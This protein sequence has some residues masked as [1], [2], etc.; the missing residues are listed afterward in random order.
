LTGETKGVAESNQLSIYH[1]PPQVK[2]LT[3]WQVPSEKP[4]DLGVVVSFGYFIPP[5]IIS[6]LKYGAVNVHPSLLPKYRGAAP[7][8]HAIMYGDAETGVTIQ[9]L[10][11]RE[12][13]AGRILAQKAFDL[14]T[15]PPVYSSLKEKLASVGSRML[16]D[17][18]RHLKQRK[19]NAMTQDV[20]KATKAPKIKKEWAEIDFSKMSAWQAEQMNRAIG[21]QYPLRTIYQTNKKKSKDIVVQLLDLHLPDQ[22]VDALKGSS[23][24]SFAWDDLGQSLHIVFGDHSVVACARFKVE[25][26]GV[27]S[28][29]DFCNGY[30][31]QGKF[32]VSLGVDDL[33]IEK[34]MKKRAKMHRYVRT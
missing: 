7:I 3:N 29:S 34:N 22:P 20:S 30:Q 33:I 24:G 1:T 25:N 4:Y 23:P 17:T 26:K 14:S 32:G 18:L 19:A 31:A 2:T 5:H 9:E 6:S 21:E 16:V 10:D 8:Q 28:A 11:D 15:S 13:D 27:I 12:F